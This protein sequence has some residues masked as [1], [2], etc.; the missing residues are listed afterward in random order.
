MAGHVGL[1]GFLYGEEGA[2]AHDD[3]EEE[4][5]ARVGPSTSELPFKAAST[6]T[7]FSVVHLVGLSTLWSLSVLTTEK[8]ILPYQIPIG[9]KSCMEI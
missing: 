6:K 2:E 3:T 9:V 4:N 8:G 1:H 5:L 7:Y